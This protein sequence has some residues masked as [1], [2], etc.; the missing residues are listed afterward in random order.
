[1][2]KTLILSATFALF[3]LSAC[4][5]DVDT[6]ATTEYVNAAQNAKKAAQLFESADFEQSLKQFKQVRMQVEGI[7]AKYPSSTIALKLVSEDNVK[8]GNF[9]SE[10]IADI[11]EKLE[12]VV[13]DV[14]KKISR[15][16]AISE[17]SAEYVYL[18]NCVKNCKNLGEEEKRAIIYANKELSALAKA[19][20]RKEQARNEKM[21]DIKDSQQKLPSEKKLSSEEIQKLLTEAE[22]NASHCA[23]E[24]SASQALLEK[25]TFVDEKHLDEFSKI[26]RKGFA[27]AKIITIAKL[28]E[29]AFANLATAAASSGDE[30]LALEIIS[31]IKNPE[32]FEFT[33]S[34]LATTLGKTKNYPA[35]LSIASNVKNPQIKNSFLAEL[36]LNVATQNKFSTSIEIAK[37]ISD[38]ALKNSTLSQIA[39]YAYDT[40]NA[41]DFIS[42]VANLDISDL[43][44]C[45][46]FAKYADGDCKYTTSG[47]LATLAKMTIPINAKIAKILTDIS[48]KNYP[49][50]PSK[51]EIIEQQIVENLTALNYIDEAIEFANTS[52]FPMLRVKLGLSI[53]SKNKQLALKL[54]NDT[55]NEVNNRTTF[56]FLVET[57]SLSDEE[58]TA[59]LKRFLKL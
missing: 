16:I 11:I 45:E 25:A 44:F 34:E 18:Y 59:L 6:L 32:S 43:S 50:E 20:A 28:R 49:N 35:A 22:K 39:I 8:L 37:Q 36:A 27:K 15:T 52:S 19:E 40:N 31:Q 47:L 41:K 29:K 56:A 7:P 33:F 21:S 51:L 3:V 55:S 1:M 38:V 5:P 13:L 58:K 4:S 10:E 2:K 48:K 23:F 57:S 24:I 54:L 14:N 12:N 46:K 26:L 53:I 30:N 9:K 42:A 17:I